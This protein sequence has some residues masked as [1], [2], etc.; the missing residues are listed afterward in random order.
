MGLH[1]LRTHP[2]I[3]ELP[4]DVTRRV[5]GR[6]RRRRRRPAEPGR[7]GPRRE[8]ATLTQGTDW[9]VRQ[10][11]WSRDSATL[12][13]T[14]DRDGDEYFQV[15]SV[16]R[17]GTDQRQLTDAPKRRT[18]WQP[19]RC[20]PTAAG[21]PTPATTGSPPTRTCC[22]ATSRPATCAPHGH[23]RV[24]RAGPLVPDSTAVTV[25]EARS[26]TDVA[27]RVAR[28]DGT[29]IP[30]LD[31]RPGKHVSVGWT[32]EGDAVVLRTD[33][34]RDF[35]ALVRVSVRDGGVTWLDKPDWD[36]E[37]ASLAAG[38]RTAVV[39]VNVDGVSRLRVLDLSD[40]SVSERTVPEC[41]RGR[42]TRCRSPP[43]ARDRHPDGHGARAG[44]VAVVDLPARVR[45]ADRLASEAADPF[46]LRRARAGRTSPPTTARGPGIPRR[47]AGEVPTA[48]CCHRRRARVPGTARLQLQ[49]AL[50]VPAV[51]GGRRPGTERARLDRYGTAYQKLIHHDWGGDQLKDLD[52]AHRYLVAQRW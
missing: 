25:H 7:P 3:L 12:F 24:P 52:Y 49:R 26:N 21:S 4:R 32:A 22:C 5:G 30:L 9:S 47:P 38:G 34:D 14:A 19:T 20:R 45:L 41:R 39:S 1:R 37:H 35:M 10:V 18:T 28:L 13:F 33:L 11:A 40:G 42:S 43:T 48:W 44:N 27:I 17:D 6:L 29:V 23:G 51:P 36:V 8:P 50:P 46:G 2:A 16:R 31:G 15:F